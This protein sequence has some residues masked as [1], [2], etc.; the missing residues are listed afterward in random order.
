MKQPTAK[1]PDQ[2]KAEFREAGVT[3]A[4]W[5]RAHGFKEQTV[6]DLLRGLS[7]GH[8]GEAHR[9]AIALGL[10]HGRLVSAKQFKAPPPSL[11]RVLSQAKAA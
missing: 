10:K 4:D 3:F 11:R 7:K 9:A 2:V 8:R 6:K 1:T 5:C